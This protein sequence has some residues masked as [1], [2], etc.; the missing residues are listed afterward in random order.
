MIS[1]HFDDCNVLQRVS[2]LQNSKDNGYV[3]LIMNGTEVRKCRT[4]MIYRV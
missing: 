3:Q 1:Q 2:A 4:G